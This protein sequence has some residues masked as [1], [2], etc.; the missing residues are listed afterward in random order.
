MQGPGMEEEGQWES[1]ATPAAAAAVEGAELRPRVESKRPP[2]QQQQQPAQ[3]RSEGSRELHPLL[4][5]RTY[6]RQQRH[7]LPPG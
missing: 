2:S 4:R 5:V 7:L 6:L 3:G 1:Q